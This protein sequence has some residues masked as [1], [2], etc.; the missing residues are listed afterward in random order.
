MNKTVIPIQNV[1]PYIRYVNDFSC[2]AG[3]AHNERIIFDCEFMFCLGGEGHMRYD[4]KEYTLRR[5]DLFYL[6][7]HVSNQF[8][9][10]GHDFHA[11]CIHFDWMVPEEADNFMAQQVYVNRNYSRE[12]MVVINRLNKRPLWDVS[13]LSLPCFLSGLD[14]D[15]MEPL[16]KDIYHCF[17]RMDL[18]SRIRERALFMQ[19]LSELFVA[20]YTESGIRRGQY[21]QSTVTDA[22]EYLKLHYAEPLNVTLLAKRAGLSA[23]YFGIQFKSITGLAV[24]E[25]LLNIRIQH[26]KS[27]LLHTSLKVEE[28]AE[29]VGIEDVFYFT[30][31]FKRHEG[32]TP[33]RYRKRLAEFV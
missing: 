29:R 16:F 25:Y 12:E 26:A 24:H 6:S 22:A 21:H 17:C 28:V 1:S 2:P 14:C 18:A 31:L 7:P 20:R 8:Y 9:T 23:K 32:I 5:G 33:G 4:T 19:I 27:L 13:G 3:I 11:H 30:K 10:A 15:I